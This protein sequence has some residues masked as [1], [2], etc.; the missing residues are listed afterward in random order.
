V[1]HFAHTFCGDQV[2]RKR[3]FQCSGPIPYT[4]LYNL[5]DCSAGVVRV[6]EVTRKDEEECAKLYTEEDMFYR[7]AKAAFT[8][9]SV[10][11]PVAVQCV[12]LPNQDEI[13]LRLMSEV[14]KTVTDRH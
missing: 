3:Y 13:C 6:T 1:N 9:G 7:M 12:A 11:L 8:S 14:E 5:L 10:G 4:A 2:V